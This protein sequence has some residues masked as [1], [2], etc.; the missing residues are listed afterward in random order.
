MFSYK[1]LSLFKFGQ[2]PAIS[3]GF[4]FLF[5]YFHDKN[6]LPSQSSSTDFK[7]GSNT[8]YSGYQKSPYFR[9]GNFRN[10]FFLISVVY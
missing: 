2:L 7:T 6:H 10:S 3:K 5:Q 1:L 4:H 8:L 9:N